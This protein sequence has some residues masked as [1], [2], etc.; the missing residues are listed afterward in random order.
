LWIGWSDVVIRD[1]GLISR[2]RELP[3][4]AGHTLNMQ[5]SI[6]T[7]AAPIV[8]LVDDD[9]SF[10]AAFDDLLSACGYTVALYESGAQLLNAPPTAK[11]ACIVLDVQM[12]DF[13]GPQLQAHL[14]ALGCR[15]PILFLTGH[16]DIPTSVQA[17][18]AGAEDFLTKPVV[19]DKLL[20]AIG[21]A[22]ARDQEARERDDRMTLLRSLVSRLTTRERE[23]FMLLVRGKLHKQIAHALGTSE[24]TIKFHRHNILQ[25][26][27]VHSVAELAAIAERLG[28]LLRESETD[29]VSTPPLCGKD[30]AAA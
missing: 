15:L 26:M 28:L 3:I 8:H 7:S 27:R 5:S 6:I 4:R 20:E 29:F 21:R 24:R 22:F 19:K 13:S 2:L 23:V 16:G 11:P 17:I 18:K 9:P 30:W 14:A 12:A 25:K 10:R 1:S